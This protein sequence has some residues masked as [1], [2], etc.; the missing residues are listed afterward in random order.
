MYVVHAIMWNM[1]GTRYYLTSTVLN[2]LYTDSAPRNWTGIVFSNGAHIEIRRLRGN[3][4]QLLPG[5]LGACITACQ[6]G[7]G[8]GLDLVLTK[9]WSVKTEPAPGRHLSMLSVAAP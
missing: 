7:S 5:I 3:A 1:L 9:L 2:L 6:V 8:G 4:K